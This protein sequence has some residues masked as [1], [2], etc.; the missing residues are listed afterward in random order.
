VDNNYD[1]VTP[2]LIIIDPID[3][4]NNVG[5]Q[6][7]DFKKVQELLNLTLL[8]MMVRYRDIYEKADLTEQ[9]KDL[10]RLNAVIEKKKKSTEN[11]K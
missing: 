11:G 7:F 1:G 6:S 5:K 3:A 10:A 8:R 2:A 9:D 4:K